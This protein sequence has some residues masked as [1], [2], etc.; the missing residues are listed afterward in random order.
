MPAD[1]NSTRLRID[2]T[3]HEAIKHLA[4]RNHRSMHGEITVALE[5]HV[6]ANTKETRR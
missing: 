1:M 3:L 6:A 2:P 4:V 5:A